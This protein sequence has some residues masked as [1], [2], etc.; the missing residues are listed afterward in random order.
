[1]SFVPP[2]CPNPECQQ[3]LHPRAGFYRRRGFY[4]PQCRRDDVP[5]F[6]CRS[7]GRS[8]SSQTFQVD[9]RDHRPDCNLALLMLL[10]SDVG[11]RQTGR[12]VGLNV[13]SV[14]A[15][16]AKM[17]KL[18]AR[19]APGTGDANVAHVR[20]ARKRGV[21]ELLARYRAAAARH[22]AAMAGADPG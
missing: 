4:R 12:M 11:L 18:L 10:A 6:R 13:K 15:K 3:H 19:I 20:Q 14:W 16:H 2:Q 7:C 21:R 8:F 22:E 17:A 5:R 1:M 9:F